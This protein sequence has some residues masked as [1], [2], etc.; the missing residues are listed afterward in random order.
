LSHQDFKVLWKL[1]KMSKVKIEHQMTNHIVIICTRNR[2]KSLRE[3]L[4]TLQEQIL[5]PHL[6]LV[7][8][9]SDQFQPLKYFNKLNLTHVSSQKGT[10]LQRNHGL[11]LIKSQPRESII[12]FFDDDVILESNYLLNV[13]NSFNQN[14]GVVG[15]GARTPDN[16]SSSPKI[17]SR[18][19]LLDSKKSGVVLKSGANTGFKKSKDVYEVDWLPGCCMSYRFN[20][21]FELRFKGDREG[22]VWGEDVDFS[23]RVG[24]CAPLVIDNN[25]KIIHKRSIQ[26]RDRKWERVLESSKHRIRMINIPG[27]RVA[28]PHVLWSILGEILLTFASHLKQK[29]KTP[30]PRLRNLS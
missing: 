7:I 30:L 16:L 4:T 26:N 20:S 11:S 5:L 23:Y 6:T 19:F 21:I 18:F 22:V 28:L 10:S 12:H 9:S 3:M 15:V 24:L 25:L 8:D 14:C 2:P 1:G 27:G 13:E 29:L 17:L